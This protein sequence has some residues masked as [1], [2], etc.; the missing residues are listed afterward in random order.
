MRKFITVSSQGGS[1][2]TLVNVDSLN[3][4]S[5]HLSKSAQSVVDNFYEHTVLGSFKEDDFYSVLDINGSNVNSLDSI[6]EIED[7]INNVEGSG[8]GMTYVPYA[9]VKANEEVFSNPDLLASYLDGLTDFVSKGK[10]FRG[11]SNN[12]TLYWT[13]EMINSVLSIYRV[14]AEKIPD[15]YSYE[16]A[17]PVN[18]YSSNDVEF[19]KGKL[20]K[21]IPLVNAHRLRIG[22]DY[23]GIL[24]TLPS[25]DLRYLQAKRCVSPIEVH[26]EGKGGVVGVSDYT[27]VF[28]TSPFAFDIV[29]D[30]HI[31][32]RQ[33]LSIVKNALGV[34][35]AKQFLEDL[36]AKFCT[37]E[38]ESIFSY[39]N[40]F[41][42][43][44]YT[45]L[46]D[47]SSASLTDSF[48][49]KGNYVYVPVSKVPGGKP[50]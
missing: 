17:F 14:Y 24:S 13:N 2:K 33:L 23:G 31:F 40:E 19:I 35:C 7:K 41:T 1:S 50:W 32:L 20:C 46:K 6:S 34:D 28:V 37:V 49:V 27:S 29:L 36:F 5:Y 11:I 48:V 10:I 44:K 4:V 16:F 39:L 45:V 9:L 3:R 42:A 26:K 47:K 21:G 43:A 15:D 8:H 18:C 12:L 30:V 38:H 25:F 22:L